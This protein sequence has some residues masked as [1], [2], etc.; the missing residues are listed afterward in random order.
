M[1]RTNTRRVSAGF[2]RLC[3]SGAEDEGFTLLESVIAFG[4]FMIVFVT[5]SSLLVSNG[6]LTTNT[7][8]RTA[9]TNLA[10]QQIE[11]MRE[12]AAN[13]QGVNLGGPISLKGVVYT[14]GVSATPTFASSCASGSSRQVSVIVT[15]TGQDGPH[16]TRDDTVIAC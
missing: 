5:V 13:G 4:M 3:G 2:G 1:A 11:L 16:S 15:W 8:D 10:S 14:V 6:R 12:Q 7:R 9:A